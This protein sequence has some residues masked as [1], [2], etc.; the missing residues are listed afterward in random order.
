MNPGRRVKLVLI[1]MFFS[2][3]ILA[4]LSVYLTVLINKRKNEINNLNYQIERQEETLN[5]YEHQNGTHQEI[6]VIE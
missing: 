6:E 4:V 1:I 3:I 5:H 2:L